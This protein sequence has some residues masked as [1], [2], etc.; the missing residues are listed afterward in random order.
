[1]HSGHYCHLILTQTVMVRTAL[2]K[3]PNVKF[4]DNLSAILKHADMP[5]YVYTNNVM[6]NRCTSEKHQFLLSAVW[7]VYMWVRRRCY[8]TPRSS[9]CEPHSLTPIIIF[10]L[11]CGSCHFC[12]GSERRQRSQLPETEETDQQP[13]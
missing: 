10:Q 11:N 8:H 4:H 2:V 7:Q 6:A 12:H 9:T 3:L 13:L 1:M 5:T